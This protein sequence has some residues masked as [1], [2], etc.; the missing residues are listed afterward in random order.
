M[1]RLGATEG[2]YL[3]GEVGVEGRQLN[4]RRGFADRKGA[5]LFRAQVRD[6]LFG[7]QDAET[8]ADFAELGLHV[9][10]VTG[11]MTTD[12]LPV[13]PTGLNRLG[14]RTPP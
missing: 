5:A 1:A 7:K 13:V 11:T 4:S 2:F 9:E 6:G 12:S 14:Q 10:I 8:V 3:S